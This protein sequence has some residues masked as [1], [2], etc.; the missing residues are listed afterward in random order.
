MSQPATPS[1]AQTSGLSSH[2][3][4]K[5]LIIA[6][7]VV[8]ILAMAIVAIAVSRIQQVDPSNEF[9]QQGYSIGMTV[10]SFD[11]AVLDRMCAAGNI[12]MLESGASDDDF[13]QYGRGCEAGWEAE[14]AR[15]G[16]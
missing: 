5:R 8:A 4:K 3:K 10:T 16:G 15:N 13:F 9:Y 7:I 14:K 6:G 12:Y 2:S 11:R 1:R